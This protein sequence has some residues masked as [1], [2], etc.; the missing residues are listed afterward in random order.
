[1]E[2]W[3]LLTKGRILVTKGKDLGDQ[4]ET[5]GDKKND[6][7]DRRKVVLDKRFHEII[8]F[9]FNGDNFITYIQEV[10]FVSY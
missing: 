6:H 8:V 5:L 2:P 1:M 9:L 4:R 10:S 7:D 3:S